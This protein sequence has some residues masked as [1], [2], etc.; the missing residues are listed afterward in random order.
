MRPML[1]KWQIKLLLKIH[2]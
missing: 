1:D 2:I